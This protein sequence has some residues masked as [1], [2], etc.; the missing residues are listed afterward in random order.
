MFCSHP[1]TVK[2]PHDKGTAQVPC[3]HCINCRITRAQ[4]WSDR[5]QAE[6]ISH[7]GKFCFVTLTYDD[8]H[9]R[10]TS[11]GL[12][13][14][15]KEDIILFIRSF[16]QFVALHHLPKFKYFV[17]GEYGDNTGRPHYHMILIGYNSDGTLKETLFHYWK[18]GFIDVQA[19]LSSSASVR[20][21]TSYIT[22]KYNGDLAK[23]VYGDA[24]PPFQLCSKGIGKNFYLDNREAIDKGIM[25]F[26]GHPVRVPKS[27]IDYFPTLKG[28][29]VKYYIDN[30]LNPTYNSA[31][32][33]YRSLKLAQLSALEKKTISLQRKL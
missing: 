24:L 25:T 20:Y 29:S 12:Q 6:I 15:V 21:V 22:K 16:R 11:E 32:K 31:V 5:I 13:T 33:S 9:I 19:P 2:L 10:Y 4:K 3:G 1:I 26:K 30:N 7:H 18:L 8:E 17:A 27:Y 14:L 23:E 28:N